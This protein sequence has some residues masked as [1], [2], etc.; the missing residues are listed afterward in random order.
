[1]AH[2]FTI[3]SAGSEG[4]PPPEFMRSPTKKH[5]TAKDAKV[6]K[7]PENELLVRI[8][9][10]PESKAFNCRGRRDYAKLAEKINRILDLLRGASDRM[11][12]RVSYRKN[13]GDAFGVPV[14]YFA[15]SQ[16]M[17][18]GFFRFLFGCHVNYSPFPL[19]MDNATVFC[20]DCLNV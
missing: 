12:T 5:L 9:T 8:Q 17:L 15:T 16:L 14:V 3:L 13:L 20:C 11:T 1:M 2:A 19:F 10:G 18:L 6:A 4:L 7:N